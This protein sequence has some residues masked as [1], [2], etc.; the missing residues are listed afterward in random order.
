MKPKYGEKA[1]LSYMDIDIFI[2]YIKIED[3]YL[4]IRKDVI[5]LIKDDLGG[6]IRKNLLY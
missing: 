2:D 4:D 1:K 5:G 6:K 3:I